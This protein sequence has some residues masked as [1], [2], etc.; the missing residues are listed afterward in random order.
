MRQIYESLKKQLAYQLESLQSKIIESSLF[1]ILRERF[2]SLPLSRQKLI[3][4]AAAGAGLALPALIPFLYFSSSIKHWGEFQEKRSA[5]LEMLSLRHKPKALFSQPS[6]SDLR[7]RIE[8]LA[9]KYQK[10]GFLIKDKPKKWISGKSARQIDFELEIQLLNVKE[11]VQ[12][13]TELH[14]LPQTRLSSLELRESRE[15]PKRYDAVFWTSSFISRAKA[16]EGLGPPP[17]R[18]SSANKRKAKQ[19]GKKTGGGAGP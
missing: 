5:S 13:G 10:D 3:K 19:T 12:L 1:N 16:R 9:K 7:R 6:E 2:E 18:R 4:Y 15:R 14:D 11:A 17:R 8:T